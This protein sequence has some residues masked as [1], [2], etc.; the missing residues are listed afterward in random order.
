MSLNSK[1]KGKEFELIACKKLSELLGVSFERS[2]QYCGKAG[3]A[4]VVGLDGLHIECKAVENLNVYKAYEQ[5]ESDCKAEDI[6]VVVF[7]K[8]RKPIMI[9][10]ELDDLVDLAQLIHYLKESQK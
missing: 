1:R 9:C 6:P 7:K 2:Q 10:F 4:D 3:D 5:A 8:N